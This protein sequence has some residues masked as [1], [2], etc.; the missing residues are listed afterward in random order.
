M[1]GTLQWRENVCV[2][3]CV[4]IYRQA[5]ERHEK[6]LTKLF[7]FA[8]NGRVGMGGGIHLILNTETT[9]LFIRNVENIQENQ[10]KHEEY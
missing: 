6:A 10:S 9:F 3:V 4:Y 5:V 8:R 7:V 2:C 1:T